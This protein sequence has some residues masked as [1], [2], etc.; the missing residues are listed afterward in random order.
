MGKALLNRAGDP[1]LTVWSLDTSRD[2]YWGMEDPTREREIEQAVSQYLRTHMTFSVFEV[3]SSEQRLRLE[4]GIIAAL[5]RGKDFA[6]SGSWLGRSSQEPEI[7]ESGMWLKQ[8][9][10]AAPLT[11]A[12]TDALEAQLN[13]APAVPPPVSAQPAGGRLSTAD[14]LAHILRL[15]A[16]H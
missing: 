9:L 12:E 3:E 5:H 10:D 7:R 13:V 11:E 14:I 1:Y 16:R 8:G 2:P 6:A 15:L 4:A